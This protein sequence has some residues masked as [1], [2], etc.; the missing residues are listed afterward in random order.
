MND[1]YIFKAIFLAGGPGS[2]KSF[3]AKNILGGTGLRPVNSDDVYEFLMK[4]GPA[5]DPRNYFP[6]QG[7][8][9]RGKVF[10]ELTRTRKRTYLDG[11]I[12]LIIDG[13]GKNIDKYAYTQ[14]DSE[15]NWL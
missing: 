10:Q 8:R 9:N 5:L 13:T 4:K 11:R 6:T 15:P 3:V 12:G 2:G 14:T 7:P 1:P